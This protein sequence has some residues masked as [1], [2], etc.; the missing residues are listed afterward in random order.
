MWDPSSP[1]WQKGKNP[2]A[3][4]TKARVTVALEDGKVE[5]GDGFLKSR[6]FEIAQANCPWVSAL[7]TYI[8]SEGTTLPE[9]VRVA[10][11]AEANRDNLVTQRGLLFRCTHCATGNGGSLDR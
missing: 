5:V 11:W 2:P 4:V 10:Q 9:S 1:G 7:L 8:K 3:G 6:D